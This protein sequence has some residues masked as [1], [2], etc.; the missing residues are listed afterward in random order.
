METGKE[1]E[2]EVNTAI[3]EKDSAVE[4]ANKLEESISRIPLN[5]LTFW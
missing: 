3:E 5:F 4:K 2:E 1:M